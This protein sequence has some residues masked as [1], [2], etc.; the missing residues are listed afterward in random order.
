MQ[1]KDLRQIVL[2]HKYSVRLFFFVTSV[3]SFQLVYRICND[4][5]WIVRLT[6]HRLRSEMFHDW[7]CRSCVHVPSFLPPWTRKYLVCMSLLASL[8]KISESWNLQVSISSVISILLCP[9]V[10]ALPPI[11]HPTIY[12]ASYRFAPSRGSSRRWFQI[13]RSQLLR[14]SLF[15][16]RQQPQLLLSTFLL[17]LGSP[18]YLVFGS[19]LAA[20]FRLAPYMRIWKWLESYKSLTQASYFHVWISFLWCSSSVNSEPHKPPISLRMCL[21]KIKPTAY[22]FQ[23]HCLLEVLLSSL[24]ITL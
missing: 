1:H 3:T 7:S 9:E 5:L 16:F 2:Q 24:L 15:E 8:V 13:E 4:L 12:S 17:Y 19:T 20:V 10:R 18:Y 22:R 23:V 6:F 21:A 11:F 14:G